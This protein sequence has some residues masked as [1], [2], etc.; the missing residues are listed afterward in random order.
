METVPAKEVLESVLADFIGS[1]VIQQA[2]KELLAL[3]ILLS[4]T[5]L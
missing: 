1:E 4:V 5:A 3:F 2:R